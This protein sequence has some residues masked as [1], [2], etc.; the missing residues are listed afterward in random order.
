MNLGRI[1]I[2]KKMDPKIGPLIGRL[3]E[4]EPSDRAEIWRGGRYGNSAVDERLD[5]PKDLRAGIWRPR[6]KLAQ[7]PIQI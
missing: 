5:L 7:I 1:R 2:R 3:P 6:P 4:F